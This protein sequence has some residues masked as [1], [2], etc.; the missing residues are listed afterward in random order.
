MDEF[1]S[2]WAALKEGESL[3]CS[4]QCFVSET[5]V[6]L[7][8][9]RSYLLWRQRGLEGDVLCQDCVLLDREGRLLR[10]MIT[11]AR[12]IL[13]I[14]E[15]QFLLVKSVEKV[16]LGRL[17][18]LV[19][20]DWEEGPEFP[21][22]FKG[23]LEL[24]DYA[25]QA[26]P[27]GSPGQSDLLCPW[28]CSSLVWPSPPPSPLSRKPAVSRLPLNFNPDFDN[29]R[30]LNLTWTSVSKPPPL[31]VRVLSKCKERLIINQ[32]NHRKSWMCICNLLVAD[33]TAYTVITV[34]DEAV[35][36]FHRTVK[37]GDILVLSSYSAAKLRPGHRKLMHNIA[38]K[39]SSAGLVL[40]ATD[41]E[42]KVNPSD[43]A[44]IYHVDSAAVCPSVPPLIT[45]FLTSHQLAGDRV[46]PGRLVDSVGLVVHHGRWERE[47]AFKAVQHWVRVWLRVVD[48]TTDT[49][50]SI[51]IYPD[52][53]SW[54]ELEAAVPGE[55]VLLTNLQVKVGDGGRFS[56]LESTNQTG[57]FA[58][59]NALNSRFLPYPVVSRF[60]E[61]LD[62][63]L[64]S[65]ARLW[66]EQGSL[67]GQF[68]AG[69]LVVRDKTP[70]DTE[71]AAATS[72]WLAQLI[73]P[74][75]LRSSRRILVRGKVSGARIMKITPAGDILELE[76][77]LEEDTESADQTKFPVFGPELPDKESFPVSVAQLDKEQ[78][79][80]SVRNVCFLNLSRTSEKPPAV[81]YRESQF[82]LVCLLLDDCKIY[83]I[84]ELELLDL[85]LDSVSDL[86]TVDIFRPGQGQEG[87]VE[88]VLRQ[89]L[90]LDLSL[91]ISGLEEETS[92]EKESQ[93]EG[94][95]EEVTGS[96]LDDTQTAALIFL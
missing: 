81:S 47:Q 16:S 58:G 2:A 34:W 92:K 13:N 17:Q 74:L 55:V 36:S 43:L 19:V 96:Q 21:L 82:G 49:L 56:H 79:K 41:I 50:I 44:R 80:S 42:C 93:E 52:L 31:V 59:Q 29:L 46:S 8:D 12:G 69:G 62:S 51:K 94:E 20:S 90:E 18:I 23:Q 65:W 78:F 85:V 45:N 26:R 66:S 22:L 5:S 83:S 28:S 25:D 86:F 30:R 39:V 15:R 76:T 11:P 27:L 10:V 71:S 75:Q 33:L 40:S 32:S 61:A 37:E 88:F 54:E 64:E 73:S 7:A 60:K 3:P 14:L 84:V 87:P 67:G 68:W 53:E 4:V 48:H 95:E 1:S 77:R 35:A 57:V 70:T 9:Q 24:S 63:N 89:V 38:P 6:Y 91:N 72:A